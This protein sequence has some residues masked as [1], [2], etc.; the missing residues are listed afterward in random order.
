MAE[1][2]SWASYGEGA[3]YALYEPQIVSVVVPDKQAVKGSVDG[4]M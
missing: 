3:Q 4:D 2:E 1:K